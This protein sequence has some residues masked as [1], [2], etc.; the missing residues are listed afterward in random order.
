LED[1]RS[2]LNVYDKHH[3]KEGGFIHSKFQQ[4]VIFLKVLPYTEQIIV[5]N[6]R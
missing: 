1:R 5:F 6:G 4:K 2:G 3:E